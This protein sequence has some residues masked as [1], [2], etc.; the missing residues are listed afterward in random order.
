MMR[1]SL[2]IEELDATPPMA[3]PG[4]ISGARL[5]AKVLTFVADALEPVVSSLRTSAAN[6]PFRGVSA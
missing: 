5:I 1:R 3:L 6:D 4:M 2:L